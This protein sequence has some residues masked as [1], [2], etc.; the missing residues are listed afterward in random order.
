MAS[1]AQQATKAK[2]EGSPC[3]GSDRASAEADRRPG[4]HPAELR[5]VRGRRVVPRARYASHAGDL[6]RAQQALPRGA[7]EGCARHLPDSELDHGARP[8]LHRPRRTRS[9]SA[10]RPRRRSSARSCRTAGSGWCWARSGLRLHARPA[11]RRGVHQVRKTHNEAVFDAYT[12]DIRKCRSSHV[13]T[14]LPDAYGRGRIIGDYRRIALY[15]VDR[16]IEQKQQG[17][18]RRSTRDVHG[19]DHPRPRGAVRAGPGPQGAAEDG[20][21][22][23]LRHLGPAA[24]AKQASSGSTSA[25]WRR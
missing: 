17:E 19:R 2:A 5:A 15:G 14:G 24:S 6:G 7:E 20:R 23:R 8:R 11:R 12:A 25:T 18:G 4:L 16:L 3:A 10:S 21:E 1:T 13:L 9:S 22:L